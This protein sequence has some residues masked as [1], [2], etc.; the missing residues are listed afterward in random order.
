MKAKLEA[1]YEKGDSQ[2][3]AAI[4][5]QI[6]RLDAQYWA[7]K[8]KDAGVT[9]RETTADTTQRQTTTAQP[10]RSGPTVAGSR[11]IRANE[12]W[13][14]DPEFK[15]ER[16]AADAIYLD[17]V[18]NE[19]FDPKDA[20][21]FKEVAK[22][23]NK[24]FPELKA[25]AGGRRGPGDDDGDGDDDD[26]DQRDHGDGDD[27]DT[28]RRRAP[29]ANLQDRGGQGNRNDGDRRSLTA[30]DRKTMTD[31]RLDPDNDRDVVQFLREAQA[32]E[33]A[34]A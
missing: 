16:A 17:L 32:L 34:Q 1:S 18:Q 25:L 21:T 33:R 22:K 6:S 19:G 20:E 13:W 28:Q 7:K 5:L 11:F 15:I 31:C 14:E 29:A 24:K 30:Q 9:T 8:A 26:V 27:R 4:T 12:D 2:E 10:K 3:S 23:L